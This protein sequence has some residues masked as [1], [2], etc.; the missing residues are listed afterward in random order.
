M[1]TD[2][3]Q[4]TDPEATIPR[5]DRV[6]LA[7][8]RQRQ[9][10]GVLGTQFADLGVSS[11]RP[12]GGGLEAIVFRARST[13]FGVVA[14]KLPLMRVLSTG[15]EPRL[16]TRGLLAQEA[17]IAKLAR[18]RGVPC[19]EPFVLYADD[20]SIDFLMVEYVETDDTTPAAPAVGELVRLIHS[21]G[22][23]H[24]PLSA[25]EGEASADEVVARRL[26]QRH[27]RLRQ[28]VGAGLPP[29]D[30]QKALAETGDVEEAPALLHMDARPANL[31]TRDGE[32]QAIVDWSN[33]LFGPPTL[34][35]A[36]I[37]ES[38]NLTPAFLAGYGLTAPFDLISPR[39]EA[40]YR[41]DTAVML[42]HVFLDNDAPPPVQRRQIARTAHLVEALE[43]GVRPDDSFIFQPDQPM[44]T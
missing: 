9:L 11:L 24:L 21:M 41:L 37:G 30:V 26:G 39:R 14:I 34:E 12:I 38:G 27:E 22:G 2:R 8:R 15:N 43:A 42:A 16:D 44:K 6:A 13:R 35:L 19:P 33:A 20:E 18:G 5:R 10:E 28:R 25:M 32:I 7:R 36:R 23:D 17:R 40:I 3:T 29:L 31:L 1:D 4:P